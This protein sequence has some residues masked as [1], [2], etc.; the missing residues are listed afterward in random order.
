M[1]TRRGRPSTFEEILTDLAAS[2]RP[3]TV[4][5][6]LMVM[7]DEMNHYLGTGIEATPRAMLN[8]QMRNGGVTSRRRWPCSTRRGAG[9]LDGVT[10]HER[11]HQTV[12]A[13]WDPPVGRGRRP[14]LRRARGCHDAGS[15]HGPQGQQALGLRAQQI[16]RWAAFG[17]RYSA[18][19]RAPE[20]YPGI[21][22]VL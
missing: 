20:G 17:S 7:V 18:E 6:A 10:E 9:R 12:P 5:A 22:T 13:G 21:V 19:L 16:P 3:V 4:Q 15:D 11:A 2:G 8:R 1:S 14:S